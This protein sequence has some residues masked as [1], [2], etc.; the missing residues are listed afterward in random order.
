MSLHPVPTD[1]IRNVLGERL[2]SCCFDPLTGYYRDGFCHTGPHDLG[3]HTV[4]VQ[5]TAEFLNFSQSVGNDLITPL[6]Q[7]GFAGLQPDD[8]WCICVTRW[9]QALDAGFAAP[10]KLA[11]CHEAALDYVTLDELRRHAI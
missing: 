2:A 7:F 3:Q 11:S 10:I 5:M 1:N 6:P 9:K 4:C 8:F